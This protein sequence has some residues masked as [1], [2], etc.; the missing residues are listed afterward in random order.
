MATTV[1]PPRGRTAAPQSRGIITALAVIVASW[2]YA[3]GRRDLR[4]DL[5]RGLAVIAMI[6]DHVGG[7]ASWL[8]TLTGGNHFWTS[9]AEGFIFISG[10]RDGARLPDGGRARRYRHGG[11]EGDAPRGDAL[12]AYR[13]PHR[14]RRHMAGRAPLLAGRSADRTARQLRHRR[15]LCRLPRHEP[16]A[17]ARGRPRVVVGP[18]GTE[19]APRV[20]AAPSSSSCSRRWSTRTSSAR[21]HSPQRKTSCSS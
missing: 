21:E 8:Y 11:E 6:T 18:S 16:L 3:G 12:S 5:L 19:R 13:R 1:F 10:L 2:R 14:M 9:A 20:W 17:T 7:E 15:H 4:F